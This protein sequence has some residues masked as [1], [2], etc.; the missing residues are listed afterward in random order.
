MEPRMTQIWN[1]W[2]K[3]IP[4]ITF[5]SHPLL[6]ADHHNAR[7]D[8]QD[9]ISNLRDAVQVPICTL[10]KESSCFPQSG[11]CLVEYK[12]IVMDSYVGLPALVHNYGQ[13]GYYKNRGKISF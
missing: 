11:N 12:S 8:V 5:V 9:F 6:I 10:D 4:W 2:S 13:F 3:E 7:L 1:P